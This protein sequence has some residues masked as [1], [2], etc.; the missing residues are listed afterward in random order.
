[1]LLRRELL[2]IL[3]CFIFLFSFNY[4]KLDILERER[5]KAGGKGKILYNVHNW[6]LGWFSAA[7]LKKYLFGGW[8]CVLRFERACV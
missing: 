2:I 7:R 5:E 6:L 3:N 8:G 4:K 1:M